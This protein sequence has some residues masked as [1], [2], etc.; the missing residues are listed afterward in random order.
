MDLR[1][2]SKR[3]EQWLLVLFPAALLLAAYSVLVVIPGQQRLRA[4]QARLQ[5]AEAQSVSPEEAELSRMRLD[6]TTTSLQRL[7]SSIAGNRQRL[8]E[9]SQDWRRTDSRLATFQLIT[10]MLR[11]HD[12]SVVFQGYM[13]EVEISSYNQDLIEMINRLEPQIA[14]E[15]WQIELQGSFL[16][17][18]QF[19]E[20]INGE[21]LGI[22][23]VSI[24]MKSGADMS[25]QKSWTIVFLI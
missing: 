3:R 8:R 18:T 2:E 21:Q 9:L 25:A 19:L 20:A 5:V 23:P 4:Q 12:L 6:S 11:Y 13:P 16:N 24:T 15:Y 10:E 14:V 7:K 22:I 17:V 1:R